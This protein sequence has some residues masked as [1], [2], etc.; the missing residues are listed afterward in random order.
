MAG[1]SGG[2]D[3]DD[4]ADDEGVVD[5]TVMVVFRSRGT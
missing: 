1:N 4:L 3:R 5:F 2:S